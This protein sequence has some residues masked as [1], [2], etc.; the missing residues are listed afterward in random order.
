[1]S[2]LRA[3]TQPD[4]AS[5]II[6]ALHKEQSIPR[7]VHPPRRPRILGWASILLGLAPAACATA[8]PVNFANGQPG[9]AVKCDLGLNGLDQC[10]RKAGTLCLDR[11]YSLRDWQG[12]QT[13]FDTVQRNVDENFGSL[14]AKT[15]LVQCNPPQ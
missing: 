4:A 13:T 6:M 12:N 1:M 5:R 10:Y 11:G 2:P 7:T 3:L 8:D 14:A 9:Y 15:I